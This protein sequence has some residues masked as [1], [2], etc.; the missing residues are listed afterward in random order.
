MK[1]FL[2]IAASAVLAV[3]AFAF[4]ACTPDSDGEE[5][6][7]VVTP[8]A[9]TYEEVDTSKSDK[10]EE[11]IETASAKFDVSKMFGNLEASDWAFG[12]KVDLTVK[13]EVSAN[14]TGVKTEDGDLKNFA[15][16]GKTNSTETLK[17][18][19]SWNSDPDA[20]IPVNIL[21][22]LDAKQTVELNLPDFIYDQMDK[23]EAAMLKDL[24][25]DFDY[26]ANAYLDNEYVYAKLPEGLVSKLPEEAG[27]PKNG[28]FKVAY[29]DMF[30]SNGDYDYDY[31]P[32]TAPVE[33]SQSSPFEMDISKYVGMVL[34]MM[35]EYGVKVSVS[36][37]HGYAI[38]LNAGVETVYKAVAEATDMTE[39]A[40]KTMVE[41]YVTDLKTCSI[42][43]YIAVDENGVFSGLGLSLNVDAATDLEAGALGNY[44]PAVSGSAKVSIGLNIAKYDGKVTLPTDL[45]SY[46]NFIEQF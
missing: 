32:A 13:A 40:V 21:G 3:S 18:N 20:F 44:A 43:A 33:E 17:L 9:G 28:K 34:G 19:L 31:S 7:G 11:L 23:E 46:V 4:T 38:K 25:S 24:Y 1:R 14:F 26:T 39:Y 10:M 12:F 8:P 36:T 6:G 29:A 16:S 27:I 35:K 15:M 5:N 30:G 41:G 42:E 37:D 2:A 45:D 22:S